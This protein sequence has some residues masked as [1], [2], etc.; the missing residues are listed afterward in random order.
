MSNARNMA[1]WLLVLLLFACTLTAC[2]GRLT[3]LGAPSSQVE[4]QVVTPQPATE[5]P[6]VTPDVV[7]ITLDPNNDPF[8]LTLTAY[9]TFPATPTP[10]PEGVEPHVGPTLAPTSAGRRHLCGDCSAGRW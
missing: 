3:D 5:Q 7:V 4:P 2:L 8:V 6:T 1:R 10:E 9:P